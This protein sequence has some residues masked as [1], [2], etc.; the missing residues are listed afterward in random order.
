MASHTIGIIVNGATGRIASTQHL[1][2]ALIPIIDEGGLAL[3]DDRLVP[4]LLLAGRDAA[5]LAAVARAHKLP[6]WTTHF[7]PALP[8]PP[9]P[10]FFPPP[11]PRPGIWRT[12]GPRSPRGGGLRPAPPACSR[13]G[14]PG[15]ATPRALPPSRAPTSPRMG[16][17]FP[18]RR[19]RPPPT[20]S[21]S[22][23]PR[24]NRWSNPRACG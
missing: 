18:T 19:S 14:C 21:S 10:L 9:P 12:P 16:P 13:I 4:H 15:A 24:R 20:P 1:A 3:G 5:R 6:A 17:P 7:D 22:T 11:P 23:P 2:N 8:G